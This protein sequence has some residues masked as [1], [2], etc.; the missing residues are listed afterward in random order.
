MS[1]ARGV[2]EQHSPDKALN[3]T[4][5]STSDNAPN[6]GWPYG[7]LLHRLTPDNRSA[8]LTL[9]TPR[10]FTTGETLLQQGAQ[11]THVILLHKGIT[12]VWCT[13]REGHESLLAIRVSGDLIGEMS[14][15]N[16]RPRSA[17]VTACVDCRASVILRSRFQEYLAGRPDA[18]LQL[19]GMVAERLRSANQ[20]RVEFAS[21]SVKV[22]LAR[23]LIKIASTYGE[24]RPEGIVIGVQLTQP[25]LASL[26]GAAEVTTQRAL[27]TFRRAGL[28]HT[29]YRTITVTDPPGL[30]LAA[31]LPT[32]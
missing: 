30:R 4:S 2:T 23:L 27:G 9:G 6:N 3:S 15:L 5:N 28:L 20:F 13:T 18:A 25:E 32:E 21:Y 16:D 8:L 19:A 14:A 17:T 11:E 1:P 22:R 10:P 24:T 29:G 26:C 12:K 31:K 7:T